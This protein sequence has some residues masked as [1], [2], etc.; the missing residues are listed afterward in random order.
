[1]INR[2]IALDEG[3]KVFE[4][5]K[6]YIIFKI[7]DI[8]CDICLIEIDN[9]E[10]NNG[11]GTKLMESFISDMKDSGSIEFYLDAWITDSGIYSMEVLTKFYSKFGFKETD[12]M[13]EEGQDR[14]F[15]HLT[16]CNDAVA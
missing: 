8:Y 6:G 2:E 12:R 10:K 14:V 7:E 3:Q 15:M 1:M 5:S 9:A 13:T 4:T 16:I 11:E